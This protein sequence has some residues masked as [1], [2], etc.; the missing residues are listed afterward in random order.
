MEPEISVIPFCFTSCDK[1]SKVKG[2]LW[3]CSKTDDALQDIC[4]PRAVIH[5]V[6]GMSEHMARYDDFARYL[7]KCGYVVCGADHIGHGKTA[8]TNDDL[9]YLPTDGKEIL[10][11][12]VHQLRGIVSERIG[13]KTP[14]ILLGH[15]MGSFIARAYMARYGQ[16]LCAIILSGTAQKPYL[17]SRAGNMLARLL[18]KIRGD[19]YRSAFVDRLGVGAYAR[20]IPCARTSQDWLAF[21]E[22]VVDAFCADALCGKMFT[23][24]GY[25]ALTDLTAEIATRTWALAVPEGL[26]VLFVSGAEDPVGNYGKGVWAA[27]RLLQ[28]ANLE[29]VTVKIFDGM[30][31]EILNETDKR[32]VYT[33]IHDWIEDRLCKQNIS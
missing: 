20:Q 25:A 4:P 31:H 1:V 14:Y 24:S 23:V 18:A 7:V 9:G 17:V 26:P 10:I 11:G 22:K 28:R 12:D 21:D 29:D 2:W 8:A 5:L 27:A 13:H 3:V 30:R 16:G 19:H 33:F 6:H 15:S 32:L